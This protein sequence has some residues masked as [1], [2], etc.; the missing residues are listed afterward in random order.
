[1]S[2]LPRSLRINIDDL[3][4]CDVLDSVNLRGVDKSTIWTKHCYGNELSI[5]VAG[6]EGG[7]HS[8]PHT[9]ASE[10][11]NYCAE[12]EV[13]IFV[14]DKGTRLNKGDMMRVP[15]DAVHW[16]WNR[17]SKPCV[18]WESHTPGNIGAQR[19]RDTAG[20]L[21]TPDEAMPTGGYPKTIWL[22]AEYAEA[23]ESSN[24]PSTE[25]GLLVRSNEIGEILHRDANK[26]GGFRSRFVYGLDSSFLVGTQAPGCRLKAHLHDCEQ[27]MHIVSGELWVFLP[28]SAY[29]LR[30]GDFMRI[31]RMVPHWSANHGKLPCVLFE[32]HAPALDPGNE[33]AAKALLL[34][35]ES[36]K[37]MLLTRTLWAPLDLVQREEKLMA[38]V[39]R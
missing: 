5:R 32:A 26:D 16:A 13:W 1:M 38:A 27:L 9:H 6:R 18:L 17:S 36:T 11:M 14:E 28:E 19:V 8:S 12:G 34:P 33:P 4:N 20:P 22:S 24:L 30:T 21:F 7:Y 23:P 39:K 25:G 2:N 35:G 15:R 3:P 10:Q 31:P 37:G 29:L